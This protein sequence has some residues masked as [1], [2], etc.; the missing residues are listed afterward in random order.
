MAG[1]LHRPGH[2]AGAAARG[3][4]T[5]QEH[6]P[7]REVPWAT[8]PVRA[9]MGRSPGPTGATRWGARSD[10]VELATIPDADSPSFEARGLEYSVER[11]GGRV[12]HGEI[13]RDAGGKVVSQVEAEARYVIGS[14]E[15]AMAFLLERGEG[16]LFESPITWYSRK[17]RWG[18]SPGYEKDN[19][20]FERSIKPTCLF[21][22]SNQFDHV[23][24]TEN[25]YRPPIFRGH[26]IGCERCHGPGELHVR[27]PCRSA[28]SRRTS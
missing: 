23:E 20:H 15:Q 13:K 4:L 9:A 16:Y 5:V 22:H 12:F 21:C 3:G 1:S 18:L 10:R 8:R 25:R 11:R 7:R 19:P 17:R 14:G 2:H 6:P 27:S 26:A 24:G 28:P